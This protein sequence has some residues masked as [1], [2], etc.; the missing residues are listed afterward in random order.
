MAATKVDFRIGPS[1]P[2]R[3]ASFTNTSPTWGSA[4]AK[5]ANSWATGHAKRKTAEADRQLQT[6]QARKRGAWAAAIGE[7]QS[8]RDIAMR[9]P[10]IISDS[11]FLGFLD[12]SKA[13]DRFE[14]VL[15]DQGRPIAQRGPQ[16]RTFAHPLAPEAEG[17]AP[18]MFEDV[19]DPYGF[20]GAAQRSSTTG[21]LTGYRAAPSQP[22]GRERRTATDQHGRLRFLDTG[23]PA[24]ADSLFDQTPPEAD[25]P[26]PAKFEHVRALAGDWEDATKPVRDLSRQRDLM[27]IG[28]EKARAGDM[29]AGSQAVLVTF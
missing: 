4:V 7:G 29:A 10:S 16:G 25:A 26:E 8:V 22:Q 11:A 18:E 2:T 27:Q 5:M 6:E 20:G 1:T 3:Y 23:E 17:P 21:E 28:L 15:D 9:D 13:P 12:K 24:F 14:D 19:L